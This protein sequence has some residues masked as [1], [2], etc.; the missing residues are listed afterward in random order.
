[1]QLLRQYKTYDQAGHAGGLDWAERKGYYTTFKG[2][3]IYTE[4]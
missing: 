4:D 3:K 1:M 2:D